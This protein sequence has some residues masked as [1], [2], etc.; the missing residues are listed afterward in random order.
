M[1]DEY[2]NISY[3]EQTSISIEIIE[4]DVFLFFMTFVDCSTVNLE[5]YR[6]L[7]TL[8]YF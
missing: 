7:V 8:K 5:Y 6:T 4:I 3:K 2:L 1:R